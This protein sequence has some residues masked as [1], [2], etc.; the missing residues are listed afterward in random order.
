MEGGE[1]FGKWLFLN[2]NENI[3]GYR[4]KADDTLKV[5]FDKTDKTIKMW[6]SHKGVGCD[7]VSLRE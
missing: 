5:Y 6:G 2:T 1:G 3:E 4:S 7:S